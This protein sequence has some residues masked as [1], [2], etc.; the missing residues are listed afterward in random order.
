MNGLKNHFPLVDV[1]KDI[2]WCIKIVSLLFVPNPCPPRA[3]TLPLPSKRHSDT[4]IELKSTACWW[5]NA[6]GRSWWLGCEWVDSER[7][8]N[9]KLPSMQC[10]PFFEFGN[11]RGWRW[12]HHLL[13]RPAQLSCSMPC[14]RIQHSNPFPQRASS[15]WS[16]DG[17]L[18]TYVSS[19][20][21]ICKLA[22]CLSPI[23]R[24]LSILLRTD[25]FPQACSVLLGWVQ[26]IECVILTISAPPRCASLP[27]MLP[28][29]QFS[30]ETCSD[31]IECEP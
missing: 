31:E 29:V 15:R 30:Q 7:K 12:R 19:V 6:L 11:G 21:A 1:E 13:R 20:R 16:S 17:G 28:N 27:V 26:H 24:H 3:S 25:W 23:S 2:K 18:Q 14:N 4:R 22:L 5:T 9:N 8:Y 10:M